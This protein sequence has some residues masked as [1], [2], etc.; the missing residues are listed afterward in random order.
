[1]R[2]II[3]I[4]AMVVLS[5][6][7]YATADWITLDV[8]VPGACGGT[9]ANGISGNNIVGRYG[10]PS[11]YG[12]GGFIY[13]GSSWTTLDA[14]GAM[15]TSINGADGGNLVGGYYDGSRHHGFIYDGTTWTTLDPPGSTQASALGISGNYLVGRYD[16]ASGTHGFLYDH[17]SSSWTTLDAP[18]V[19]CTV[20]T[21]IS[22]L[23]GYMELVGYTE[24]PSGTHG[25]LYYKETWIP[26]DKSGSTGTAVWGVDASNFV[27]SYADASGTHGFLYDGSSWTT[28]DVP[29]VS[30][31]VAMGIDGSN[32]VGFYADGGWHG[33]IH[34]IPQ[35]DPIQ[36]ILEFIEKSVA[37]GTLVPVKPGKPGEGQLGALTNMIETAGNLIEAN[38]PNLLSDVCGQLH[39][40]LGKTDG[41]DPPPD[42]VTGEATAELAQ[43]IED[44]MVSLGCE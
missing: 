11:C 13:N 1:M 21:G 15:W 22:N 10:Y 38:D 25:F 14:P 43:R 44:L 8:N 27:G 32:I 9:F 40:A 5:S 17:S 4:C 24:G 2:K 41:Q 42:F 28:L 18:G 20:I 30:Y 7:A 23:D 26:L 31:T 33:F 36:E 16:N 37:D 29:G 12:Y 3:T 35:H 6:T 34:T 39:A 19:T